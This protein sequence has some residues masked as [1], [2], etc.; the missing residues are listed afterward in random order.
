MLHGAPFE[1]ADIRYRKSF[2]YVIVSWVHSRPRSS[3]HSKHFYE[4][5]DE[6]EA[7]KVALSQ[8]NVRPVKKQ[9]VP[10][11]P[12]SRSPS[13]LS[14]QQSNHSKRHT[15]FSNGCILIRRR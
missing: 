5:H 14:E 10:R 15:F 2:G 8:T 13:P 3:L 11:V 7:L 12:M 6:Q 1:K 4:I 9:N